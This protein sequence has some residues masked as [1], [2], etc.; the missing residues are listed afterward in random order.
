MLRV[1]IPGA[2]DGPM[3]AGSPWGGGWNRR[4]CKAFRRVFEADPDMG[5][6]KSAVTVG[7]TSRFHAKLR[8]Q[9]VKLERSGQGIAP[10]D[11]ARVCESQRRG[12]RSLGA[13]RCWGEVALVAQGAG[14]P[15]ARSLPALFS[16]TAELWQPLPTCEA[17]MSILSRLRAATFPSSKP[18]ASTGALRR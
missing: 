6:P 11:R 17:W 13:W 3:H 18:R 4:V 1:A 9:F 2:L 5:N 7:S 10:S 15:I 14:D 8:K 12:L 16:H